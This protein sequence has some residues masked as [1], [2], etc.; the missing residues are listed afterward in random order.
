MSSVFV[1]PNVQSV[2]YFSPI[3]QI[4]TCMLFKDYGMWHTV[5]T[6][7][8]VQNVIV[9]ILGLDSVHSDLC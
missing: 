2:P 7:A 6:S 1:H 9:S 8:D 4:V 5:Y 3:L